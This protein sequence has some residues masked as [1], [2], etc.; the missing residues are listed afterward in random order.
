M[1]CLFCQTASRG[2]RTLKLRCALCVFC[3]T[4]SLYLDLSES[5]T[6]NLTEARPYSSYQVHTLVVVPCHICERDRPPR[7]PLST[8]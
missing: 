5:L 8:G 1:L 2:R 4:V 7:Y 6:L 3:R